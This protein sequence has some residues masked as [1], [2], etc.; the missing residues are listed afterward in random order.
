MKRVFV[1]GATGFIGAAVVRRLVA[2]GHEV[3]ALIRPKSNLWRLGPAQDRIQRIHGTL[4]D[5]GTYEPALIGFRP[6]TVIHLGW[7][8]S[9]KGNRN[10]PEQVRTN[11]VGSVDLFMSAQRAGCSAFVG[12]G[13]QAE[14]ARSAD[15]L[16][17]E[18]PTGP[19]T[20]YGAAKLATH[21]L[22]SQLAATHDV[23]FA[24]LRIFSVYGPEDSQT[25]LV[26]YV[27]T[28]L[29]NGRRPAVSQ[30]DQVWDYLYIDDAASAITTAAALQASGIYNVAYGSAQQLRD[31]ILMIRN[32]INAELPIGFGEA[33]TSGN[34]QHLQASV[35][36]LK[37]LGWSPLTPLDVGLRR[38]IEWHASTLFGRC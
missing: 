38:S 5:Q 27:T 14:Y 9:A 10:D 33:G 32:E 24:W 30:G 15:P 6:D 13:S 35:A 12:T 20:L 34:A 8:G 29:L 2:D 7:H 25:T 31:T 26:S 17:E 1:T 36:K 3:A 22:L 19:T 37:T 11:V 21:C 28:E 18:S 4:D 16:T 23:R